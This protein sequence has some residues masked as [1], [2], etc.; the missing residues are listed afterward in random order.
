MTSGTARPAILTRFVVA[1]RYMPVY[2]AL[3]VQ[4]DGYA[5]RLGLA[6]MSRAEL[7]RLGAVMKEGWFY[8]PVF[9]LLVFLLVWLQEEPENMG[10]WHYMFHNTHP[11]EDRGYTVRPVARTESGS[12]ATGSATI[13]EQE[14]ADLLDETFVDL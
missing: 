12:P 2:I 1:S 9:S 4:V 7:P 11:I 13:H 14:L 10:A 8:I 6:G 5:A 3:V